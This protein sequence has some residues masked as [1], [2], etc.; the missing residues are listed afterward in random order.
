MVLYS[1]ILVQ[2]GNIARDMKNETKIGT[3]SRAKT[4]SKGLS[5]LWYNL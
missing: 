2:D 1:S 3:K 5:G 4:I